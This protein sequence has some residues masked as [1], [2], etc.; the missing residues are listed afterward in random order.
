MTEVSAC[1]VYRDAVSEPAMLRCFEK[2]AAKGEAFADIHY[3]D[4]RRLAN[5]EELL[6]DLVAVTLAGGKAD[7]RIDC[8]DRPR[9]RRDTVEQVLG[10]DAHSRQSRERDLDRLG[11]AIGMRGRASTGNWTRYLFLTKEALCR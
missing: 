9:V 10:A 11:H 2:V 5:L 4:A 6:D 3:D 1:R 8:G 7:A